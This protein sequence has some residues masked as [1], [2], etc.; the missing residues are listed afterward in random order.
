MATPDLTHISPKDYV[1]AWDAYAIAALQGSIA[2]HGTHP[3]APRAGAQFIAT[4]A[5]TMMALRQDRMAALVEQVEAEK[6][7]L[8]GADGPKKAR[9]GR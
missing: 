5:D 1:E 8:K 7:A 9:S 2:F 4:L 3:S 6:E